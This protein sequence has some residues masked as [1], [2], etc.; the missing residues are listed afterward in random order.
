MYIVCRGQVQAR[1]VLDGGLPDGAAQDPLS[2]Q[3]LPPERRPSWPDLFGCA[4]E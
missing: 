1:A 2:D 3:D 4:E